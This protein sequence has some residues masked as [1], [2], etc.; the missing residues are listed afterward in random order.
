M[1]K[2]IIKVID[3]IKVI[4]LLGLL[5]Y[6][7]G[8]FFWQVIHDNMLLFMTLLLLLDAVKQSL[9]EKKKWWFIVSELSL[10]LLTGF[11]FY[12]MTS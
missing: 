4:C 10:G 8:Y 12:K 9:L 11:I 5:Y 6:V 3:G 7:Y 2:V 1:V